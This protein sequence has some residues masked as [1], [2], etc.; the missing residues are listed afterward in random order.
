MKILVVYYSRS[1]RSR[2]VAEAIA[3]RLNADLQEVMPLKGY[4]GLFG[5][6]R[7]GYQAARRK[8]PAIQPPDREAAAY[9]LVLF[10][11]PIWAG[12]MS[13][14]MRSCITG[15][16]AAIKRYAF[17]CTAGS[18]EQQAALD[19]LRELIGFDP[20]GTLVLTS[21]EVSRGRFQQK[22]DGFLAGLPAS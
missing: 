16:K 9:D 1:G 19:D 12:R 8:L 18:A 17:F 10:G 5:F 15:Q 7:G 11:T 6:F 3:R 20:A 21:P 14:P 2:A 22:L 13:S 4:R